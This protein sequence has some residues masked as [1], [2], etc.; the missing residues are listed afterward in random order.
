[1]TPSWRCRSRM[2]REVGHSAVQK[3]TLRSSQ[4]V[5]WTYAGACKPIP[6]EAGETG[7]KCCTKRRLRR[8]MRNG[9]QRAPERGEA[10]GRRPP[11]P[12]HMLLSPDRSAPP[13]WRRARLLAP[14]QSCLS[15]LGFVV[16]KTGRIRIA[17][18]GVYIYIFEIKST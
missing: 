5:L 14:C 9:S 10:A 17:N 15:A 12:A 18:T 8:W 1:M 2:S 11:S 4:A 13:V 6:V 3:P 16:C 7:G